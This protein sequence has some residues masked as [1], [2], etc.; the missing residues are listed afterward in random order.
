MLDL[1]FAIKFVHVLAV[2]VMF[3]VWLG[4]AMFMLLARRSGNTSVVAV[5]SQFVVRI[6]ITVVLAAIA[7][8]PISGV[9]LAFAIGVAP[10]REFWIVI[11]SALYVVVVICWI[12]AL[13][14][15]MQI[16][17]LT[18]QAALDGAPLSNAYRRLFRGW[19][20]CS[21]AILIGVIAIY[22]LMI[23][24]PRLDG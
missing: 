14:I 4:L 6:Q 16:R 15:E 17:D 22:A 12:A 5:T 10:L 8:Q 11:G 2:T 9:L 24:Q 7:L 20:A 21:A 13:R 23:W 18:R 3:G 1:I 19:T